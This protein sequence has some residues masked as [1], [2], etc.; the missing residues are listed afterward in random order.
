MG[1]RIAGSLV[2]VALA[3]ALPGAAAGAGPVGVG[4]SGWYWG[5]PQPQGNSLS[6]I[7]VDGAR[8][9]AV[10]QLGTVLRTDDGGATWAGLG[11][12]TAE[13]LSLVQMI[14]PNT[15]IAGGGCSLRRSDNA[16]ATFSRLPFTASDSRCQ[17]FVSAVSF[18]SSTV[19]YVLLANGT[20]LRTADGGR[21]FGQRTGVPGATSSG[22]TGSATDI[23]FVSEDVG[24]AV[25]S[26]RIYRTVNGGNSWTAV[27]AAGGRVT[28]LR[29][30]DATNAVAVG[31]G[32]TFLTS[33]DGG[34]SFAARP[35]AGEG[36]GKTFTGVSCAAPGTCVMTIAGTQLVRTTDGG[37]TSSLVAT[38]DASVI[39]ADFGAA[40]RVVGVGDG[41]VTV[42]SDDSGATFAP[43]GSRLSTTFGRL[44]SAFGGRAYALGTNGRVART[45]DGGRNWTAFGVPTGGDIADVSF[46]A[47]SVG[48]ALDDQ[49][50]LLRTDNAGESW[51]ILDAGAS[52]DPRAVIAVDPRRVAVIGPRGV[53]RSTNG[54]NS[55]GS[56]P[57][58]AVRRASLTDVDRAGGS[59]VAWGSKTVVIS[60]NGGSSWTR[61]R[62]P[63]GAIRSV[64]FVDARRGFLV[65]AGGRLYATA[66]GGRRWKLRTGVGR[67]V[68]QIAFADARRGF[69]SD[70]G[71]GLLRTDD[72]GQTWEPQLLGQVNL[73]GLAAP[74]AGGAMAAAADGS[75]FGTATGGHLARASR[76][77]LKVSKRRLRK[78]GALR[79]TGKLT[80]A[81]PGSTVTLIMRRGSRYQRKNVVVAST[82]AFSAGFRVSG[83]SEFIAQWRGDD[84]LDG[85]GTAA[86][87]VTVKKAKAKKRRR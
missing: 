4:H 30:V 73:V 22:T 84:R 67:S 16:G 77:S 39:A 29:F 31:D 38:A 59:I 13:S 63:K 81:S 3:L 49:G 86:V 43:V 2:V 37:A 55:F 42:A 85:D 1:R 83:S 76:L 9:Y 21:T 25:A 41:G 27:S 36:A 68:V 53:R 8:G 12:G 28:R 18:T 5:N 71:T 58:K 65:Q 62:T 56:S 60:R 64:D 14:G 33:S 10:G 23:D 82:G 44:R 80:P 66:N 6:A 17:S 87:K 74:T 40:G 61:I 52:G 46:P 47:P 19:G 24:T 72:G 70:G 11:S 7:D 48:Y 51:R 69:V 34:A 15:V 78:P 32:G 54:G 75:L 57:S 50:A 45:V 79:V 20:V 35:L 26:G